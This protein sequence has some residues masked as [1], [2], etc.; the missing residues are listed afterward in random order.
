[1]VW[2]SFLP[3][4][5]LHLSPRLYAVHQKDLPNFSATSIVLYCIIAAV[6][7]QPRAI[8]IALVRPIE[9]YIEEKQTELETENK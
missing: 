7:V 3:S 5:S 2:F 1:M 4:E 6:L 8:D 9:R